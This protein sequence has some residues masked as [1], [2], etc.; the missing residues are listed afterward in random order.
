VSQPIRTCVGCHSADE[1]HKLVRVVLDADGQ[2]QIDRQR[3]QKG[4]GAY[5]HD[6]RPCVDEAVRHGG[7]QKAFRRKTRRLE[8]GVLWGMMQG[9]QEQKDEEA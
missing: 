1:Q 9:S 3:R 2:V 7:L 5:L 4:R 6:R 8:A